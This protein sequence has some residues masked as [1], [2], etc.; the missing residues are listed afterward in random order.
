MF[1]I[2]DQ[3]PVRQ[4]MQ[5]SC[6]FVLKTV[7]QQ[8]KSVGLLYNQTSNTLQWVD[9]P[10]VY[11]YDSFYVKSREL[12][13]TMAK[14][15]TLVR[16]T[17]VDMYIQIG[18]IQKWSTLDIQG[19][20]PIPTNGWS[21]AWESASNNN[22]MPYGVVIDRSG[23]RDATNTHFT[24][25]AFN[26]AEEAGRYSYTGR[27][28]THRCSWRFKPRL[29]YYSAQD[30]SGEDLSTFVTNSSPLSQSTAKKVLVG[31]IVPNEVSPGNTNFQSRF[32]V[33]MQYQVTCYFHFQVSGRKAFSLTPVQVG[34]RTEGPPQPPPTPPPS[35][36]PPSEG[37]MSQ[38]DGWSLSDWK[39]MEPWEASK[40]AASLYGVGDLERGL[41][42]LAV[43]SCESVLEA[44][45]VK[46]G[47]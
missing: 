45:S 6:K 32:L 30:W 8:D 15:Y 40:D 42:D 26:S 25:S 16:C 34:V 22:T 37:G 7:S 4:L 11:S 10:N 19:G 39:L 21:R 29:F 17:G 9:N 28:K 20:N 14:Q 46:K 2:G 12:M 1:G 33:Y 38:D 35:P 41:R 24:F 43:S 13:A 47:G 27:K 36:D 5:P 44:D 3:R 31:P 18:N 23:L